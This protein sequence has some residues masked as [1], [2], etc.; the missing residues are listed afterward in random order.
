[1]TIAV[2]AWQTRLQIAAQGAENERVHAS[3]LL[4]ELSVAINDVREQLRSHASMFLEMEDCLNKAGSNSSRCW[5]K[6]HDFDPALAQKAWRNLDAEIKSASPLLV[7]SKEVELL[8]ELQKIKASH[9][10]E[11]RNLL[12]PKSSKGA[13]QIRN[14]IL[15]TGERLEKVEEDLANLVSERT[16]RQR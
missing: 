7:A 9:Q 11:L 10:T 12:P 2:G 13:E 15:M 6:Q 4:K 8:R 3:T 5:K 1:L 14:R 16:R